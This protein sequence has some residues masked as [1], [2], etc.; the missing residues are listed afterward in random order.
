MTMHTKSLLPT[1][2][3]DG[4]FWDVDP[5]TIDITQHFK[6]VVGRVLQA[7]TLQ[8]WQ[9]L[10]RSFPLADIVESARQLRSLEPKALAFISIVGHVPKESFRCSITKQST[11]THWIY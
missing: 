10:C 3:S 8:D 6:Y 4:L 5:E 11:K 1:D 7:G 9:I 2:F